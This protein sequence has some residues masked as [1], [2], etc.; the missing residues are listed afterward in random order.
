MRRV[1]QWN[2][3]SF[4]HFIRK[5]DA[6]WA[7]ICRNCLNKHGVPEPSERAETEGMCG[8]KGCNEQEELFRVVIPRSEA[9]IEEFVW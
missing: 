6:Y 9:K 3:L 5:D 2:G 1:L 8:S 7:Y 4:E